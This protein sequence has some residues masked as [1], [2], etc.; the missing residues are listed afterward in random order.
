MVRPIKAH[1]DKQKLKLC[2]D[3]AEENFL[4]NAFYTWANES[5]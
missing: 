3:A 2:Q 5:K 4:Y 1:K